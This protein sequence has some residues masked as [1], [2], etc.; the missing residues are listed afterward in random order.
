[1]EKVIVKKDTITIPTYEP[2]V[3]CKHP[4]F[5]EKRV[6]QGCSGRVYPNPVIES[7]GDVK[8]DKK[9]TAIYLENEYLLVMILPELGGKIQRIFDKTN[10]HDAVYYNH[11]IKPVLIGLAGIWSAGGIEFGWPQYHRPSSFEAIDYKIEENEDGSATVWC[12]EIEKMNH[13]KGMAGITLYPD[14][15]YVE[16]K[17]QLYNPNDIP[18]TFLWTANSAVAANESTK[19]IFPPDVTA[20]MNHNRQSV[21]RFPI[22]TGIYNN[23]DYSEGVDISLYKNI[24]VPT[25]YMAVKSE[26]NFIGSYDFGKQA[27]IVHVA[28]HNISP[29]KKQWTWGNDNFAKAWERNVTDSD[30]PYIEIMAGI[31]TLNQPD[32][33]YL[34]PYE[35]KSFKQYFIPY[36]DIGEIKNACTDVMVNLEFDNKRAHLRMYAPAKIQVHVLLSGVSA[37]NYIKKRV[38]LSPTEIY[39]EWIELEKDEVISRV[40]LI[41]RNNEGR[42][43][44]R[45][46]AVE[47]NT[48]LPQPALKIRAPK[49]IASM[50]ELY[51]T[52]VHLEQYHHA[53]SRPED[54]YLEGLRRDPLD[55]RMNN[56]YGKIMYKKGLFH[57]AEKYFRAAIKRATILNPNPYDCEPYYNLGIA[58]K[59]QGKDA[60]AVDAFYKS[61]WDGK[62]QDKG[63]F[64]LACLASKRNRQEEALELVEQSLIRGAHNM[65]ART[66]KCALL[67]HM[68]RFEEAIKFAKESIEI[69]PLDFGG[70]YELFLLTKNFDVLNELT[71]IMRGD[72]Q[73][74]IELSITYAKGKLYNDASNVLALI[75]QSD[76]PMLHYYM[77]KYSD[78][79]VEL[80]IA[81]KCPK[82]YTFPNRLYD[83]FVLQY[84][85]DNNPKD[86]FARYALGN[87]YYDKG[88]WFK[89]IKYWRDALAI[90]PNNSMILR[91]LAIG[92]YN[93]LNDK[94][95]AI[96][97]ME[98][99]YRNAPEDARIYYELDLLRKLTNYPVIKRLKEMS[100]LMELISS[101]DDL[102]TEFITL[103][104]CE[105]YYKYALKAINRHSFHPWEGGEGRITKQYKEAH[106]GCAKECIAE[107]D[108][109]GAEE[110]LKAALTYPENLGEGK[111]AF[112]MDNDVYYYLGCAYENVD[113]IRAIEFFEKATQG[114]FSVHTSVNYNNSLVDMYY[115]RTLAYRKLGNE[116]KAM[117]GFN[118]L[119]NYSEEHINDDPE[120][121]Y[122]AVSLPD[123]IIF[124]GDLKK[125]NYVN[126]CYMAALGYM[127]KGDRQKAQEFIE[128]GLEA[129]CSHQGL[130]NLQKTDERAYE[131]EKEDG[132]TMRAAKWNTVM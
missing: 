7:V 30:G 5:P 35:E 83:I 78:S 115:Y 32:F 97:Y 100:E 11:V 69:D 65:A 66:I 82:D 101:R 79:S 49:D 129:N 121:D 21:S 2:G 106:I 63:Y 48:K 104:N 25:S 45:Y 64:Q 62:M 18:Q 92:S 116:R 22:A 59:M 93:K 98:K 38:V 124:E 132:L 114:D 26:Y 60:E 37:T 90:E 84:A 12:G 81:E 110:L 50:E 72:L 29:G 6:Y 51:L 40:R 75:S 128:K 41:V 17:G 42:E 68:G 95:S 122:F 76:K 102:Y 88:V 70:K 58:L 61:I 96:Q 113:K 99:A 46:R 13:T 34:M 9:Y 47:P 120:I 125:N 105:K 15:A 111:F 4:M 127:G 33:T 118:T 107:G 80:E 19:V 55:T 28:N 54:Y 112:C 85:I 10:Q 56:G 126:C 3:P 24:P 36:K 119:I 52:A 27:G 123:F 74:Y 39:D 67:R 57:D 87:L 91:N 86:W 23:I 73:N 20:V 77:A 94:T 14:K 31:F 71:T 16:I 117:G 43:I 103:L 131:P 109:E 44:L 89:A 108:Y 1:M 8:T 53:T 130:I